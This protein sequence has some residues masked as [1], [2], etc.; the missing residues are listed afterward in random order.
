M[1]D[2]E[3]IRDMDDAGI[4]DM[5]DD[6][7]GI[8]DALG[9]VPVYLA[10]LANFKGKNLENKNVVQKKLKFRFETANVVTK[11]VQR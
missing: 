3:G 9:M 5:D 2:V 11:N 1:V 4:R 7:E 10:I 8:R 6:A